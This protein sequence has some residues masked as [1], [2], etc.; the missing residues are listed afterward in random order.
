MSQTHLKISIFYRDVPQ[1]QHS[2]VD[3]KSEHQVIAKS[4]KKSFQKNLT[5]YKRDMHLEVISN[6][7]GMK[8]IFGNILEC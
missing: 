3:K 4:E 1:C 5:F 2:V 6:T 7:Y 8:I